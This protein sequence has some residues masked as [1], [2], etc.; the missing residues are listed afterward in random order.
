MNDQINQ[1]LRLTKQ[2]YDT[3]KAPQSFDNTSLCIIHMEALDNTYNKL[4]NIQEFWGIDKIMLYQNL[5]DTK[6]AIQGH[7]GYEQN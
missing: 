4:V 5:A 7:F 1:I 3:S 2:I 6:A